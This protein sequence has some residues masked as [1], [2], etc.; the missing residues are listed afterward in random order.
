MQV[1]IDLMG[2]GYLAKHPTIN[3]NDEIPSIRIPIKRYSKK[4]HSGGRLRKFV[5]M[6][7]IIC[8]PI[9]LVVAL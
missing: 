5:G 9:L 8:V 6:H 7:I 1:L 3:I 4:R 2:I